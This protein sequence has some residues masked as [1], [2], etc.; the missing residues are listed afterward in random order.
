MKLSARG[1]AL[2]LAGVAA[3]LW[4]A[5][6]ALAASTPLPGS[7]GGYFY[8]AG[9]PDTETNAGKPPNVTAAADGVSPGNLGVAGRGGRE[10]KVS[11]LGFDLG[12][13]AEGTTVTKAILSVPLVKPDPPRDVFLNANVSQVRA[14]AAGD[15]GFGGEDGESL[16]I[17]PDRLCDDF[18]APATASADGSRYEFDITELAAEWVTGANDGVAL[19]R[20]M[21]ASNFQVVFRP[22]ED[23][24]LTLETEVEEVVEEVTN[25]GADLGAIDMPTGGASTDSGSDAGFGGEGTTDLAGGFDSGSVDTGAV[26]DPGTDL[27]VGIADAPAVDAPEEAVVDLVEQEAPAVADDPQVA[28]TTIAAGGGEAPLNPTAAFWLTGLGLA[29]V[30]ALLGLILGDPTVPSRTLAGSQ[31]RLDRALQEGRRGLSGGDRTGR[32]V[33]G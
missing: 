23:A 31:S 16:T 13:L 17:A 22:A 14:C 24:V 25:T 21:E 11:F 12:D 18:A 26:L 7:S 4:L 29:G 3:P 9:V 33:T 10:E 28:I 6:P 1:C 20:S 2:A 8:A 27:G 19:T 32:P 30:L 5:P 15:Q